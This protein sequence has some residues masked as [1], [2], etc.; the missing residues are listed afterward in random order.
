MAEQSFYV[1]TTV[2]NQGTAPS[3]ITTL[4]FYQSTDTTIT[5]ADTEVGAAPPLLAQVAGDREAQQSTFEADGSLYGRYV[6]LWGL[7]GRGEPGN[8]IRPT[9]APLL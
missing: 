1:T 2:K 6:L 8:R 4:R 7:R 5:R 9:T 3:P